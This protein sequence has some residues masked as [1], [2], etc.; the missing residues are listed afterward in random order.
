MKLNTQPSKRQL[1]LIGR[2]PK[3]GDLMTTHFTPNR[4][5]VVTSVRWL[6]IMHDFGLTFVFLDDQ[7]HSMQP[8]KYVD[9]K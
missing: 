9:L 5:A 3:V 6:P 7:E 8:L 1:E 4:L 2:V